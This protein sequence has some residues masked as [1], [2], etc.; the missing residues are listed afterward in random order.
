M[1]FITICTKIKV[2][3]KEE[4]NPSSLRKHLKMTEQ[5][6]NSSSVITD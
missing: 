3:T 4:N 1:K 6:L 5:L 2:E